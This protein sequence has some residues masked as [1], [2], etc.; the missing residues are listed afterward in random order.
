MF[1]RQHNQQNEIHADDREKASQV[2]NNFKM[3]Q[4]RRTIKHMKTSSMFNRKKIK[5]GDIEY[6]NSLLLST[7]QISVNEYIQQ[8]KVER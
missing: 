2:I 6:N 7:G 1:L 8:N 5:D 3:P 4:D